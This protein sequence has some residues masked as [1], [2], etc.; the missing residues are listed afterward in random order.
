M[1]KFSHLGGLKF[2]N[3]AWTNRCIYTWQSFF[4]QTHET[5][6]FSTVTFGR[7]ASS[8]VISAG[9]MKARD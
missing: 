1:L 2:M 7:T 8:S 9:G 4:W 3:V 6:H 5:P